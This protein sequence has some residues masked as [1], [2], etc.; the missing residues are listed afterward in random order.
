MILGNNEWEIE[1]EALMSLH[2][3]TPELARKIVIL[4][5]MSQGDFK[6]LAAAIRE[7]GTLNDG[8][9]LGMLV[10][11]IEGGQLKLHTGRRQRPRD[12]ATHTRR[13]TAALLYE[14]TDG[15]TSDERF[16]Q[17]A[18]RMRMSEKFVRASYTE[19]RKAQRKVTTP[20]SEPSGASG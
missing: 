20:S 19:W 16:Q 4:E 12:P 6:P 2:G 17:V 3:V 10:A 9:V 11:M 15:K 13:M 14:A 8:H 5:W 1:A 7:D 18:E